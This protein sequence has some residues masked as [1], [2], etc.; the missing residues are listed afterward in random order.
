MSEILTI[1]LDIDEVLACHNAHL[2]DWHNKNYGTSHTASDYTTSR[3]ME[4]WGVD[5][6]TVEARAKDFFTDENFEAFQ[7]V[8]G[9]IEGLRELRETTPHQYGVITVRR[10]LIAQAT[11]RWLN[12]VYPDILNAG[13]HFAFNQWEPGQGGFSKG[14]LC[15]DIGATILVDDDP[16]HCQDALEHGVEPL[17]FGNYTWNQILPLPNGITR[18]Y[19]WPALVRYIQAKTQKEPQ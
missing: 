16:K 8:P 1:A 17:L 6:D 19:D 5:N 11:T 3:W 9:A 2:A 10:A 14:Q 15:K 18:V 13:I 7:P 4:I 12:R